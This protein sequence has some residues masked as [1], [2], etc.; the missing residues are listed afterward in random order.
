MQQVLNLAPYNL[1][2]QGV[3]QRAALMLLL[4]HPHDACAEC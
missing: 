4:H 1:L 3:M 2:S